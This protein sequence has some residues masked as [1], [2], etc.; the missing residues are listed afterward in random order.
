MI[1]IGVTYCCQVVSVILDYFFFFCSNKTTSIRCSPMKDIFRLPDK[2]FYGTI[3]D[4]HNSPFGMQTSPFKWICLINYSFVSSSLVASFQI[5]WAQESSTIEHTWRNISH[6]AVIDEFTW[7]KTAFML[8]WRNITSGFQIESWLAHY[9]NGLLDYFQDFK[10]M[11]HP[12]NKFCHLHPPL[13]PT[14]MNSS[15][16]H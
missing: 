6:C 12:K 15:I 13:C 10:G 9:S 7:K 2:M 8:L 1:F 16:F 5:V 3:K 14:S 11:V 4:I